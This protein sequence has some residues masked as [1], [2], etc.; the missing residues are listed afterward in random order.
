MRTPT[1]SGQ[2]SELANALRSCR[3]AFLGVA[4]MSGVV[5]SLYLSGSFFMLEVYDR[6]I[7]SRSVPTLVGLAVL[8]GVLYTFQ[9]I[10]D[11]VRNRVLVRIG[12]SL[13][14]SLNRRTYQAIID[15]PLRAGQKSRGLQ[16]LTDLDQVRA[17]LSGRRPDGALRPAMDAALCRHLLPLPPVDRHRLGGGRLDAHHGDGD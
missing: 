7:P 14:E 6:V 2:G 10:L 15:L 11:F 1:A 12:S 3:G 4:L 17:F 16:P 8:I 5:N 9:G 13:D